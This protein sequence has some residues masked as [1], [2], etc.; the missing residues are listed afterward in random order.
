[1]TRQ[2]SSEVW[3][4]SVRACHIKIVF[5]SRYIKSSFK[6]GWTQIY[7]YSNDNEDTSLEQ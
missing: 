5:L 4:V 6:D 2:V 3:M 7:S 1:M